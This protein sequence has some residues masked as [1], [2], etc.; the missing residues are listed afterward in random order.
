MRSR[1]PLLALFFVAG[2][3]VIPQFAHAAIPF[4]GPIV[5]PPSVSGVAFSD[6]CPASWSMLIVVINNI[7]EFL[8][9]LI[10]VFVLPIMI[11]YSGFLMVVNQ[12]NAAKLSE[13]KGI[14]TNTIAGVVI[15]LAAWMIV[16]AV[17]V[18][19]Y[20]P[21]ATSGTTTLQAWSTLISGNSTD[22][23]LLQ[24]GAL[25]E[26]G[27]QP[28]A[29]PALTVAPAPSGG[30]PIST[31]GPN[32]QPVTVSFAPTQSNATLQAGYAAASGYSAQ[33][34]SACS[35]STIPNCTTVMTS[36]IAAESGGNPA[37]ACN[38]SN[39][40]GIMQLTQANG[41]TSCAATDTA[42]IGAQIAKG[43]QLFQQGYNS[44]PNIPNALAA[45]NSGITTQAG[46]SVSG[47]NSAMVP[48]V[49]CP[50]YYAWQCPTNPGGLVETQNYVANIC[51]NIASHGGACN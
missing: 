36:L 31:V 30:Q 34:A 20:N 37:T 39:A 42:C 18:A 13:A 7:V 48:S 44:F 12:G 46:Q 2:S 23:C 28:G 22:L 40:C 26:A 14:L 29:A 47:R 50:G 24:K 33:I 32:G 15:A 17:M 27:T 49:N 16:D 45:Y 4:F 5:P 41:G 21:A 1:I 19:L 51:Q 3:F 9:T 25:P 43:V 8:L 11:A 35:G 6:V 10:L 38:S